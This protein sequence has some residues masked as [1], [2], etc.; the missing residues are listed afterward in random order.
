MSPKSLDQSVFVI[1]LDFELYWGVRDKRRIEDY[2]DNLL[3]VRKVVPALLELFSRYDTKATWATVGFLF[4]KDKEELLASFPGVKPEYADSKLSPYLDMDKVGNSEADDLYHFGYSLVK[5][6]QAYPEQEIATHT[7]SHYYCLERGQT[8]ESFRHDLMAA[9]K[10][11]RKNRVELKSLVFPRNQ[12]NKDYTKICGSLGITSYRGNELSWIYK[13]RN[14]EQQALYKRGARLLDAYIT[15]SGYNSYSLTEIGKSFPYNIPASRFLRPYSHKLKF[16]DSL[17]LKRI[18]NDMT[19]AA[20]NKKLFHLWW[21]PHNFGINLTEN[22]NFLEKILQHYLTL[23]KKYGMQ[24]MT[25]E[26][27][28]ELLMNSSNEK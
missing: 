24:S 9:I 8:A 14:E 28:A 5:M 20:K 10:I 2:S 16:L 22:L 23:Q 6:I 18:L 19:Y 25:M 15:L 17:R 4:C 11:A 27:V 7:Y 26:K 1:S 13:E 12:Y 3:G 21:H